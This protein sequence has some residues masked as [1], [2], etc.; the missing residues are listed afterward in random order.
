M[1][2]TGVDIVDI[3]RIEKA[4]TRYGA[5]FVERVLTPGERTYCDNRVHRIAARFAAKEAAAKALGCGLTALA[6]SGAGWQEFEVV[7][8]P[9][10]AP[11]L[12]MHGTARERAHELGMRECALSLTHTDSV[13]VA[14]VVIQD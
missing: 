12:L 2:R 13:A 10:G 14:F 11:L 5:R 4:L 9:G 3:A 1:L 6:G 8:G 7:Q